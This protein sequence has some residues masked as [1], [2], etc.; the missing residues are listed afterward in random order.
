MELYCSKDIAGNR[1]EEKETS[2]WYEVKGG[3]TLPLNRL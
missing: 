2:K 3:I 1:W